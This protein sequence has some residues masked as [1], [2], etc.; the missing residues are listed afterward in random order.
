MAKFI[1]LFPSF[2]LQ[3]Q[4]K[5]IL[6]IEKRKTSEKQTSFITDDYEIREDILMK[7]LLAKVKG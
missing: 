3:Q 1:V 2:L 4:L 5:R 7:I 6:S